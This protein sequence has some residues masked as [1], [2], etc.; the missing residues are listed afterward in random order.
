MQIL[1]S[2]HFT[3][4]NFCVLFCAWSNLM[5]FIVVPPQTNIILSKLIFAVL[6]Q[7]AEI[8]N[9]CTQFLRS[10]YTAHSYIYLAES[11]PKNL[12]RMVTIVLLLRALRV[13]KLRRL[14]T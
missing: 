14:L 3:G 12:Q 5:I 7:I 13:S 2:K 9:L 10:N 8:S 11:E 6:E 1:D 4:I